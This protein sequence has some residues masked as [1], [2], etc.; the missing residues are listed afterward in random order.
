MSGNGMT[1]KVEDVSPVKKKLLFDISWLEVKNEL[2]AV[3]KDVGKKAKVKGF[4]QGKIPRN[5]L[6][7]MYK[8]YAE[9]EAITNLVNKYYWEALKEKNI[10]AVAQP[11]IDQKGIE[12]EKNFTFTATVE[13]E[14]VIEPKG[15]IGLELEKEDHEISESDVDARLQEVR[16][17]FGTMVEVATDRGINDGDFAVIDFEGTLNGKPLKEMKADNYLLE[18]G[19]KTFVP[20]FEEQLV[21]I[22]KGETKQIRV[23]LPDDYHVKH[24]TGEEVLF[25]VTL[26]NIKEKQLPE[27]DETFVQNFDKYETLDDLKKDIRKTLAEEN[28]ARSNSGFKNLIIDRL[29]EIN[30]F[31]V[32]QSFVNR[33]V[34]YM[35]ADMQKR[36]AMRGIKRQ[37]TSELSD[38]FYDLYK[39]EALKI[40][41]SILLLKSI[42][43]KESIT[44]SDKELEEKIK[45]IAIQRSQSYDSL[46]KSLVDGNMIDDI[47]SEILNAK[48]FGFIEDK[49]KVKIIKK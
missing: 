36:M 43:E 11:N 33:Q 20:G 4:R 32:P 22:K 26:K 48:V 25:L 47:K 37:E 2:D 38:K 16:E 13:V 42:A 31:E 29:L 27:I 30:K 10:N 34:S 28:V 9:D 17:M 12:V 7:S 24:L 41:M 6:E 44:V 18:V 49:S 23:R 21:G 45:E 5:I 39:D 35:L 19:S 3:Y 8:D 40:V 46:K 14:P 1:V 15:Y